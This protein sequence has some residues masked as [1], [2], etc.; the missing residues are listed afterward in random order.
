M[1]L[2]VGQIRRQL[3]WDLY[4][5]VVSWNQQNKPGFAYRYSA[6][7]TSFACLGLFLF[8]EIAF[9]FQA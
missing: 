5:G 2:L 1:R 3:D 8:D 6:V 7:P 4:S 9:G